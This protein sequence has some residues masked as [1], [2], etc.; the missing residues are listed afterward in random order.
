MK[1]CVIFGGVSTE[2]DISI[3]SGTS[4]IKNLNKDILPIYIDRDGE[5]YKYTKDIDEI[6]ILGVG[7][8]PTELKKVDNI[9]KILKECDVIFPV[10]H[11]LGGEELEWIKY[12][13]KLFVIKQI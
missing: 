9:M 11:G 10:L 1:V 12:M 3:V 6:D 8:Q 7:E 4:V 2:Y 5:W 13:Q